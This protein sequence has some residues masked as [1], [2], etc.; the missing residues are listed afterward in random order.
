VSALRLIFNERANLPKGPI[1]FK[2]GGGAHE[3][4][5]WDPKDGDLLMPRAKS[6]EIL[7]EARYGANVQIARLKCV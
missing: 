2:F 4:T 3:R 6:G 5:G 7:M 1:P